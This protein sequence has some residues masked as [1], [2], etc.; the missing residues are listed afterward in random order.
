MRLE[1]SVSPPRVWNRC[2]NLMFLQRE[3]C[4]CLTL[5]CWVTEGSPFPP[6]DTVTA[7]TSRCLGAGSA[8]ISKREACWQG[9][10]TR[11]SFSALQVLSLLCSMGFANAGSVSQ[12]AHLLCQDEPCDWAGELLPGDPTRFQ[13]Q[14]ICELILP[15]Y[16]EQ[17]HLS[18]EARGLFSTPDKRKDVPSCCFTG[19]GALKGW[20][21][22]R[23]QDCFWLS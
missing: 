13:V 5:A 15:N 2:S 7:A 1:F 14:F 17:F 12:T 19:C 8:L 9:I 22:H 4:Q 3:Q 16:R 18:C 11:S 20:A 21:N 23:P 6:D 10:F